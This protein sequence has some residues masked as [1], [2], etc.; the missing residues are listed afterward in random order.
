MPL[1]WIKNKISVI[2]NNKFWN[3]LFR[4]MFS[5]FLGESG[6]AVITV[7]ITMA[8]IWV[9]GDE[10]NGMFVLAQSYMNIVDGLINFQ[11]WQ[12]VIKYGSECIENKDYAAL[13]SIIKVGMIVDIITAFAGTLIAIAIIPIVA[14]FMLWSTELELCAAVFC[15]EIFFHFSGASVGVLRLF[16]RFNLV[17]IQK[18]VV[19]GIKLLGVVLFW[20]SGGERVLHLVIVYTI[21]D[22]VGHLI[23]TVM[24]LF[25]IEKSEY[26]S[27]KELITSPTKGF[28]KKFWGFAF[29]TN[30]TSSVDIPVKQ[31]DVFILSFMSYEIVSVFKLYKQIGNILVQLSIPISQAIMPQFSE[32]IAQKKLKECYDVMMKIRKWTLFVMLPITAVVSVVS[33]WLL[34][35]FFGEIYSRYFYILTLYL[36]SRSFAL[37]YTSIHQLF[38][39]MGKV[40]LNFIYTI[41]ANVVYLIFALVLSKLFGIMG[42]V[43]ALFAEYFTIIMLKKF[44]IQKVIRNA[45]ESLL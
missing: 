26:M 42:I 36:L 12:A 18:N 23:L 29:W 22:I 43:I 40:K 27:I 30:L 7:F 33:P 38:V 25:V 1:S 20:L 28:R 17:A 41:I 44:T 4:N 15:I 5:A 11:S 9:I 32:L 3:K 14:H 21:A 24:S 10:K 37:S 35:H 16:N 8:I 39:S 31:L 13:R 2:K 34:N 6:S 45:N 19:A